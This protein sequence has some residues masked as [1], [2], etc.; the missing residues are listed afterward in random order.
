[1]H[2]HDDADNSPTVVTNRTMEI[3]VAIVL[4]VLSAIVIQDSLRVGAGWAENEGPRAGYFPFYIGILLGLASLITLAK[5]VF[6][7]FQERRARAD[8]GG[9]RTAEA[10]KG[11]AAFVT[12]VAF[13]RVMLVLVPI[14]VY[15]LVLSFIG[16]Y[17]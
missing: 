13:R 14:L 7:G 8:G 15:I 16:I 11:A 1:M 12:A 3:V 9:R 10:D 2:D 4:M 17:I 6:T 5:T